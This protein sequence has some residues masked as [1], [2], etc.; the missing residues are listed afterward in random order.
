MD[1]DF[2]RYYKYR[3]ALGKIGFVNLD[4][5]KEGFGQTLDQ[6]EFKFHFMELQD[7][8]QTIWA[9]EHVD[10]RRVVIPW[11]ALTES[12]Q[13]KYTRRYYSVRWIETHEKVE[14]FKQELLERQRGY[15]TRMQTKQYK[16]ELVARA[17]HPDRVVDWCL[18]RDEKDEWI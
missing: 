4:F 12:S 14:K 1:K 3:E 10:G 18:T 7:P 15:E 16:Q 8:D 11:D 17:W 2:D 13:R 9:I 5:M 6:L